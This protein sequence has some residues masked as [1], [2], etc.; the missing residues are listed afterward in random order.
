VKID[1]RYGTWNDESGQF[2]VVAPDVPAPREQREPTTTTS[3]LPG[4]I[5][6]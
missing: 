5:G 3:V 1:P 2:E 4:I 6:G